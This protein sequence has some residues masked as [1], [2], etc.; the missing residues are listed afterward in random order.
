M[1]GSV[2]SN[3][4]EIYFRHVVN[5]KSTTLF[6][7]CILIRLSAR[8]DCRRSDVKSWWNQSALYENQFCTFEQAGGLAGTSVDV[9]LYPLDTLKTRL[10]ARQGFRKSGG[11]SGL[12]KGIVPVLIG[13]AP[14]GRY[15]NAGRGR[16]AL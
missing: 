7:S 2:K 10:Q 12:Y 13:S 16:S 15:E 6:A 8:I 5:S 11:F 9:A 3:R 1:R 4:P 14:T